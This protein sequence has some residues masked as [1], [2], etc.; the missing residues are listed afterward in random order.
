M[1]TFGGPKDTGVSPSEG[2]SLVNENNFPSVRDFFLDQQPAGTTGLARRLN[3]ETFYIAC[4]WNFSQTPKTYLVS[5]TVKVTNPG[6]GKSAEAKPVDFGPAKRTGRVAD[7][8]PGL[9]KK[10]GLRTDDECLVEIP[11]P[12]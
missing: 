9:A 12:A 11:L 4:R 7:L 6:N 3:P 1:S 2:L 10:L 8:S 5:I